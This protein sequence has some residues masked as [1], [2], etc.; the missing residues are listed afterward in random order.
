LAV[1]Q[2][3]PPP[4][5]DWSD[6]RPAGG[7]RPLQIPAVRRP[8]AVPLAASARRSS[9]C[10]VKKIKKNTKT[11]KKYADFTQGF[12]SCFRLSMNIDNFLCFDT[13]FFRKTILF[14]LLFFLLLKRWRMLIIPRN[15]KK[16]ELPKSFIFKYFLP[17]EQQDEE[18]EK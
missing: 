1:L 4:H 7:L 2:R 16:S 6:W 9:T 5:P 10:R 18:Q 17:D 3:R 15:F 11:A 14:S 8:P 12:V 13:Y